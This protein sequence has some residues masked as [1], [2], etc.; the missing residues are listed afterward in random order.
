MFV[1]VRAYSGGALVYEVNPYDTAVGTL[2]GLDLA[3]SPS[4][5]PLSATEE[6]VDRLVYEMNP[7]SSLTGESKTFHFVL[8]DGRYKDNRIPPRGFD[9]SGAA[10]RLVDPV[11]GGASAP[12]WPSW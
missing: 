12:G 6:R 2:K 5:P 8:A 10:A 7:S 1:N 9:S 4:S 11:Y 3:I